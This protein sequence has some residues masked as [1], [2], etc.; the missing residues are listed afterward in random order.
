MIG[1]REARS[2]VLG[3]AVEPC[4]M[5]SCWKSQWAR[6]TKGEKSM[7][8]ASAQMWWGSRLDVPEKQEGTG[9]KRPKMKSL[10]SL[11]IFAQLRCVEVTR[12]S[13]CQRVFDSRMVHCPNHV[14][15]GRQLKCLSARSIPNL[16]TNHVPCLAHQVAS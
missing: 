12:L 2:V 11:Q 5:V 7:M 6:A 4:W 1:G 15:S 8:L 3:T 14:F 10:T 13:E 16:S 9:A